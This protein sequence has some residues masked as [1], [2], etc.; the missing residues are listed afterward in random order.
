MLA[1]NEKVGTGQ[2]AKRLRLLY[3]VTDMVFEET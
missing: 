1:M 2:Y 3:R